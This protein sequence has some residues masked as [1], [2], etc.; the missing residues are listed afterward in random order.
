MRVV[1]IL[2]AASLLGGSAGCLKLWDEFQNKR[3]GPGDAARDF[4]QGTR[5]VLV[6]LHFVEGSGP[7]ADAVAAMQQEVGRVLGKTVDVTQKGGVPGKGA[8][9]RYTWD[10]IESLESGARSRFT[11][12]ATAVLFMLYVDGGSEA[13]SSDGSGRVLGAAYRGTSIVMFKGNIR[14]SSSENPGLINLENKPSQLEVE[15]AVLVHEFGHALGL[16][17]NGL[18]MQRP[19]EMKEDPVPET[20]K[21]EGEKH[22][23]N[24][25]GVM[26]W[27]VESSQILDLFFLQRQPIPWKFDA[28][29]EADVKAAR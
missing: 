21:N 26:F 12:D 19:H 11:D 22:S 28:D 10:E 1:A 23:V 5:K 20:E 16:V 8:T 29:D 9:H 15:R 17:N 27:A 2:L 13:D 14:Q 6:D 7:N 18:A 4:I 3:T 24:K 25:S